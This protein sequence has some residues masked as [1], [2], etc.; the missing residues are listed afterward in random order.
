MAIVFPDPSQSPWTGPNEVEYTW[1]PGGYWEAVA[2]GGGGGID[3]APIDGQQYGRQNA[4]WS[5]AYGAL[6]WGEVASDGRKIGSG[7][8]FTSVRNADP[9]LY[10]IT[11]DKPMPS[12]DYSIQICGLNTNNVDCVAGGKQAASFLVRAYREGTGMTN[13]G[14]TFAVFE[15]LLNPPAY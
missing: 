14:F 3:D 5:V 9:G 15:K 4:D 12:T 8:N 7:L 6:A 10:Q 13:S 1:N 11:F 2:N